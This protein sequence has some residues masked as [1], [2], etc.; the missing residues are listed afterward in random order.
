MSLSQAELE[1]AVLQA[2]YDYVQTQGGR[3]SA[4]QV[5]GLLNNQYSE[6]RVKMALQALER[7]K[8]T[9]GQ[10]NAMYGSK[11]E[12]SE[13][14]F[15]KVEADQVART[16]AEA[17][18]EEQVPGSDRVVGL[19]HNSREFVQAVNDAKNLK[20]QLL[21]ANDVGDLSQRQVQVAAHEI[22]QIIETME[23]EYVRPLAVWQR[24]KSVLTWVGKEAAAS[25]VGV[26][27]LALLALI[28]TLLGFTV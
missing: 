19:D 22:G 1:G 3:L 16:S 7:D 25:L 14:G 15:K 9:R 2:L 13:N 28:A 12:I 5:A 21:S 10:H 4:E 24:S 20:G 8:L 27:A 26:A 11:Y 18:V 17:A 23:Q 6:G